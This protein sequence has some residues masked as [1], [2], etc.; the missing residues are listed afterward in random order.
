MD[1]SFAE[2]LVYVGTAPSSEEIPFRAKSFSGIAKPLPLNVMLITK[3]HMYDYP[4]PNAYL[5][6]LGHQ[7]GPGEDP[8]LSLP[9]DVD[10]SHLFPGQEIIGFQETTLSGNRAI[11]DWR[12]ERLDWKGS[13]GGRTNEYT[14][15]PTETKTVITLTAMDVRTFIVGLRE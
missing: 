14:G 1:E 9:V 5:V 15:H 7:Y 6:R 12:L 13:Q 4:E 8:D 10:L 11:E 2:P 3:K